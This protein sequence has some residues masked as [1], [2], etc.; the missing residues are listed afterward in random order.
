MHDSSMESTLRAAVLAT[1]THG[2]GLV[3][4]SLA[5]VIEID[6]RHNNDIMSK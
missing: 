2:D 5:T 4:L 3:Q 1:L 6:F